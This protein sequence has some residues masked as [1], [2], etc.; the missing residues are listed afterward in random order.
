[1][2]LLISKDDLT[3]M[4]LRIINIFDSADASDSKAL[5]LKYLNNKFKFENINK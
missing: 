4:I 1:M 3:K 2:N 5:L